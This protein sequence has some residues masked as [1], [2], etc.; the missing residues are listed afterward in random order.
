[1]KYRIKIVTF[2]SGRKTYFAQ[3]KKNFLWTGIGCQS[4]TSIVYGECESREEALNRIDLH[5]R[6]NGKI[7]IIQFEYITK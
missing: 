6:G 4:V 3:V 1:M 5:F 2:K 7:Q